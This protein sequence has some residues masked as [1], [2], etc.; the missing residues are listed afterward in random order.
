MR[1]SEATGRKYRDLHDEINARSASLNG[2]KTMAIYSGQVQSYY[3][4]IWSK[5]ASTG[6]E[7]SIILIGTFGTANYNFVPANGTLGTNQK[8]PMEN[9]FDVWSWMSTYPHC[10]DLLRNESPV[11]FYYNDA[12]NVALLTTSLEPVGEGEH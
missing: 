3:L 6:Y 7:G 11:N 8:R 5:A 9:V 4:S 1:A 12:T 10:V 2:G